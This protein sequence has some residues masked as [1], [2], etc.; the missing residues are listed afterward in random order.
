MIRRLSPE[1]LR[2]IGTK[3][4][5]DRL[6]WQVRVARAIGVSPGAITRWLSGGTPIPT[7]A[8]LLL[9][10]M[11]NTGMPEGYKDPLSPARSA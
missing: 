4:F 8:S 6:G 5:G 11:L 3:L 2:M 7:P 1:E 9:Q 10:Y